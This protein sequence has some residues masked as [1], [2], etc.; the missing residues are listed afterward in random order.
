MNC[1][2]ALV[3]GLACSEYSALA[4]LGFACSEYLALVKLIENGLYPYLALAKAIL[5][6]EILFWLKPMHCFN[7]LPSVKT[8]RQF[9]RNLNSPL[10]QYIEYM[11]ILK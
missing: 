2:R 7:S 11:S 10:M 6:F 1:R 4:K 9:I 3:D 5:I 8:R